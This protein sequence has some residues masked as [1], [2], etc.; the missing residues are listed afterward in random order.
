V[1]GTLIEKGGVYAVK[2]NRIGPFRAKVLGSFT[3]RYREASADWPDAQRATSVRDGRTVFAVEILDGNRY[4][5][6]GEQYLLY[7]DYFI[8]PWDEYASATQVQRDAFE[9]AENERDRLVAA[10]DIVI[11]DIKNEVIARGVDADEALKFNQ[12]A[13]VVRTRDSR[14][15]KRGQEQYA[16]RMGNRV[17]LDIEVLRT[18]L[19]PTLR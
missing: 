11:N 13:Y 4:T 12:D 18:L 7:S 10:R 9:A 8:A 1:R 14:H 6:P 17:S 19:N 5:K 16:V 3:H 2:T 15:A